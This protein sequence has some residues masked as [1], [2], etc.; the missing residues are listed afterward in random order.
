MRK[1]QALAPGQ[2]LDTQW[3][4]PKTLNMAEK[5]LN[6]QTPVLRAHLGMQEQANAKEQVTTMMAQ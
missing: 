2:R 6:R 4:I 1:R 3:R 5:R